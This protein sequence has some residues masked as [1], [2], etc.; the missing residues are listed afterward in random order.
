MDALI[1]QLK[2]GRVTLKKSRERPNKFTNALK[3]MFDVLEMSNNERRRSSNI[4]NDPQM[5]LVFGTTSNDSI[6]I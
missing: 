1:A 5:K 3:E 2:D 6:N 4:L